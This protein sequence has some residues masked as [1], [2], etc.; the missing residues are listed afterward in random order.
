M[1]IP[2]SR[3]LAA[4]SC[5]PKQSATGIFLNQTF[6]GTPGTALQQLTP[7]AG[8]FWDPLFGNAPSPANAI[9]TAG[10]ALY[11]PSAAGSY[12]NKAIPPS[13]DY[14]VETTWSLLLSTQSNIGPIARSNPESPNCYFAR[15][16]SNAWGLFKLVAG[17]ATQLGSSFSDTWTAGTRVARLTCTGSTISLSIG[18]AVVVTATDTAITAPGLA[19]FRMAS[20]ETATSGCHLVSIKAST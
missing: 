5:A 4:I 9:D 1:G 12:V 17:T 18:G 7:T 19:G 20:A 8:A 11:S 3:A 14:W 6:T 16:S 10:T 15:F 13:A 2:Y